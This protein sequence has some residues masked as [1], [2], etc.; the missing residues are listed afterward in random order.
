MASVADE[1][2]VSKALVHYYFSTRQELLR[3]AFAFSESRARRPRRAASSA[4]STTGAERLERALLVSIDRDTPFAD[5]RALWNE[6][7]SSLRFDDELRPLVERSYRTLAGSRDPPGRG[8]PGGRLGAEPRVDPAGGRRLASP[9]RRTGSTRCSTSV[10]STATAP[11]SSC[12]AA[13]RRELAARDRRPRPRRRPGRPGRRARSRPRR[14]GRPRAR[15]PRP[16]RRPGRAAARPDGGRPVQLGGEVVGAFHTAY[17]GLVEELGLTLEPSYTARRGRRPRTTCS[18]ASSAVTS[19][20]FRDGRGAGRTTSASSGCT[21]QLVDDRR[22]GRPVGRIRTRRSWT[23][24]PSGRGCARSAPALPSIRRLEVGGA[25]PRRTARSSTARCS[26]SSASRRPRASESSTPTSELGVAPGRGGKRRGGR[27]DG[28]RAR[29]ARAASARRSRPC[30]VDGAAAASRSRAARSSRPRRSSARC[31]VGVLADIAIEG[32][33]PPTRLASL[34]AQR[35]GAGGEGRRGLPALGLG[36]HGRER[37]VRGRARPRLDVAAAGGR[38]LGARPARAARLPARARP[39]PTATSSCTTS[40]SGCTGRRRASTTAIHIRLWGT[41]PFTRG[42]VT[43]WWPGDVLRVGP[44]H[45]THD[46]PFYVCGSDQWV[47]GYMEGAVR[48]G[49]PRPPLRSDRLRDRP[50]RRRGPRAAPVGIFARS[51]IRSRG[52][53]TL[54]AGVGRARAARRRQVEGHRRPSS[55]DAPSRRSRSSP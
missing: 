22:S 4:A 32:V 48:T 39:T 17:L 27:A 19:W 38:A 7:W 15:G 10:C 50:P 9:R 16:R 1:A 44:L 30:R 20:P 18:R 43:H 37:P 23:A 11:V 21:A 34:R 41:D 53:P 31:P 54:R 26:P 14:R 6:V 28:R 46:P 13:M 52:F 36:R 47:A 3:N 45:G 33:D 24:S 40:S 42:Y 25:L 2:G 35:H 29:R 8:G 5:Q 12:S 51:G 49:R 55:N